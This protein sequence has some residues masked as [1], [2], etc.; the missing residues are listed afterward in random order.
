MLGYPFNQAKN[1]F[2]TFKNHGYEC[3]FVGGAVRDYLLDVDIGDVDLATNATPDTMMELFERTVPIG[4][5]HGTV[6]ILDGDNEFEV[7]TYRSEGEYDDFRHPNYV[8]F[9][10]DL[11]LDLSRRD[12]T[13]NAI[14]MDL[15][16]E[17]I[18]PFN[19]MNDLNNRLIHTVG[20]A[21]ERF[22][23]DALRML[24]AVR[25]SSQLGFQVSNEVLTAIK[26]NRDLL[27]KVAV[28]RIQVELTK[29]FNGSNVS[30]G[31][32]VMEESGLYKELPIFKQQF[33]LFFKLKKHINEPVNSFSVLVA[34]LHLLDSNYSIH[35]WVRA[36]K[37]SNQVKKDA[38]A[39]VEIFKAFRLDGITNVILYQLGHDLMPQFVQLV[40]VITGQLLDLDELLNQYRQLPIQS[41]SDLAISGHDLVKLFP[42]EKRGSWIG[43]Y[44]SRVENLVLTEK[45][46]NEK[47]VIE[48]QVKTWK[49]QENS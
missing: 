46:V 23:E 11:T 15:E 35:E 37:L 6:L 49:E 13:I 16:G 48:S 32:E 39:L 9:V 5:E 21:E 36:Y 44:L 10:S 27:G 25:F 42:N 1:I 28:E 18:D 43:D 29:T 30:C 7:T 19:G 24:R 14:A 38:K 4:I 22:S 47:E 2:K 41:K 33:S 20:S 34:S 45:L 26:E 40:N 31:L 17:V 8:E 3:Y 12:F